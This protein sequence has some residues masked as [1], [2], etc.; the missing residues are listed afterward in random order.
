MNEKCGKGYPKAG[1]ACIRPAG[2]ASALSTCFCLADGSGGFL[3]QDEI[4]FVDDPSDWP[5]DIILSDVERHEAIAKPNPKG[6]SRRQAIEA[7][8]ARKNAAR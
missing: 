7:Q 8:K 3:Y 5:L 1:L 6:T 4:V 2:H